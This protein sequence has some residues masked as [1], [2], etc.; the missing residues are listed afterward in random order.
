ML[1]KYV[2]YNLHAYVILP[3]LNEHIQVLNGLRWVIGTWK[4]FIE[5]ELFNAP[6]GISCNLKLCETKVNNAIYNFDLWVAKSFLQGLIMV[7][8]RGIWNWMDKSIGLL[9]GL[10]KKN[11]GETKK[12]NY[13]DSD[14]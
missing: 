12:L 11:W 4:A 6:N 9:R 7:I 14:I 13:F 3:S 5:H 1:L 8:L 2:Q 10:Y